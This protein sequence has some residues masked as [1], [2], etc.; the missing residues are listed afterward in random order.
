[1]S[2]ALTSALPLGVVIDLAQRVVSN[3]SVVYERLHY[4]CSAL[5]IAGRRSGT[6]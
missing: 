5:G 1:M 3:L 6:A 4:A 2:V